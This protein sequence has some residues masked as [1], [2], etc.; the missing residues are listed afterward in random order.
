MPDEQIDLLHPAEQTAGDRPPVPVDLMNRIGERVTGKKGWRWCSSE[1]VGDPRRRPWTYLI[2]GEAPSGRFAH[3]KRAG[4]PKWPKDLDELVVTEAE[5]NA[6]R[7]AVEA[8]TGKCHPCA[9]SGRVCYRSE[10][11]PPVRYHYRGC[12]RCNA[13]GKPPAPPRATLPS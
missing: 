4:Q 3:G 13:S 7:D 12:S 5:M 10:P 11:G 1:V 9:G 2:K 8:E 6:E